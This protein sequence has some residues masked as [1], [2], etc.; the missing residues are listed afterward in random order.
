MEFTELMNALFENKLIF[1]I[2]I[3]FVIGIISGMVI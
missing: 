2:L 1:G 3:G